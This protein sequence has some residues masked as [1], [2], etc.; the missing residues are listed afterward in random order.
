MDKPGFFS[1]LGGYL[2]AN[3]KFFLVVL[4]ILVSTFGYF[5]YRSGFTLDVNRFFA[6]SCTDIGQFD[7]KEDCQ[8][9]CE[10]NGGQCFYKVA[11]GCWRVPNGV[12]CP[13]GHTPTPAPTSCQSAAVPWSGTFDIPE[14]ATYQTATYHHPTAGC[15]KTTFEGGAG[16]SVVW[17]V[18]PGTYT[19]RWDPNADSR[20]CGRYQFDVAVF[21]ADGDPLP[22][23][24]V[25]I[26]LNYGVSCGAE[27]TTPPPTTI[28]PPPTTI[29]PPPT[30]PVCPATAPAR[31]LTSNVTGTSAVLSWIPGTGGT[32]QQLRVGSNQ[33]EVNS[34]CQATST[35]CVVV[36]NNLPLSTN[37]Y[38]ITN[39]LTPGTTYYWRVV[40]LFQGPPICYKDVAAQFTTVVTPT[41]PPP[42]AP[43]VCT[44]SQQK[45]I[46]GQP[47]QFSA[48][49]G[50]GV[51]VWYAPGGTPST[52]GTT[53]TGSRSSFQ[54]TYSVP[55][56]K[57]VTVASGG[58]QITCVVTVSEPVVTSPPP[59]QPPTTTITPGSTT[60]ALTLQKLVRNITQGSGEGDSTNAN[61]TDT[62][63]FSLRVSSVGTG[64]VTNVTVR[65]TLPAGLSYVPG[66]TTI[67]GSPAADG[68]VASG[69]NLGDMSPGRTI[70]V[71]FRATVAPASFF[72]SGTSVLTNTGYARGSNAPEISDVAFV[73]IVNTPQNLTM[74]LVKM[75]RNITRGETGEHTPVYS[76]PGQTIEFILRVRNTSNAPLT[77]VVLRDIV[78]A[79][80]TAI[81]GSVRIGGSVA[82]DTLTGAGLSLGTLAVGQEVVVTFSGRVAIAS[83]LPAGTTTLINSVQVTAT[84]VGMLTAQ[85]PV[86][87]SSTAVVVPT[88]ETGPGESTVLAL[89]I[90]GIITLLYVGYTSTDTY[91]R[92]EVGELAKEA[93]KDDS[94]NFRR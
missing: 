78:P 14:G 20:K 40:N 74:S 6:S 22:G 18:P 43:L 88:V 80:I 82:P 65:D 68:I 13:G 33:A 24:S 25:G 86:I 55:G 28:T 56:F 41:S 49:G 27:P 32:Y 46:V 5:W 90:S 12:L 69:L 7:T 21:T 84:G 31:A 73:T 36:Q 83:E 47:A 54:T 45:V 17:N 1:S 59:T 63:E 29:S 67:D 11:T 4:L 61:P 75:G 48:Q 16:G 9:A 66:S 89:I 58:D 50:T 52:S 64:A 71:R 81:A 77:N 62:V 42:G 35:T 30:T 87:I 38:T 93:K 79:G 70:T 85:L 39:L 92:R 26:M 23:N 51:Y 10:P 34:G 94:F 91:R 72:A 15:A 44:P 60:P 3:K 2:Q 37:S 53:S 76:S 19:A 8:L 57:T